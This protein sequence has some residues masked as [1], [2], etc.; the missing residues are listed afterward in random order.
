MSD[1]PEFNVDPTEAARAAEREERLAD[2]NRL[3]ER[4][5]KETLQRQN[6]EAA[7][8]LGLIDNEI[9]NQI[10]EEQEKQNDFEQKAEELRYRGYRKLRNGGWSDPQGNRYDDEGNYVE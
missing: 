3:L 1:L 4:A 10:R 8:R 9:A 5:K 7:I 2:A 6:R